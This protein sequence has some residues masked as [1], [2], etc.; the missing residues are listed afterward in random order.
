M[1]GEIELQLVQQLEVNG[2]QVLAEHCV[3]ALEGDFL[4]GLG[5]R[6]SCIFLSGVL[7]GTDAGK[8]LKDLREKFRAVEPVSFVA[9]INTAT[10]MDKVIIEKM[11]VKELAGKPERFEYAFTLREYTPL[12]PA[13][14]EEP[15]KPDV[16]KPPDNNIDKNT[17]TLRV[18]VIVEGQTDFDYSHVVVT[19]EGKETDGTDLSRTLTNR[20]DNIWT[21]E[22]FPAG[23]FTIK[24]SANSQP[25]SGS[26]K[27]SVQAGQTAQVTI[28]LKAVT[29]NIARAF[30]V[31]F[32]FDKA[33]I[34]PCMRQVL[35]AAAKYASDHPDE[36]L[37]IAGHTDLVGDSDYNQSL[38]E[39][40]ARAVYAY[41]T[42]GLDKEAAVK[43]WNELRKKATGEKHDIKD[44]WS[45]REYQFMLQDLD[46]YTGNID[47]QH[48]PK[49][50]AAIRSFQQFHS[51]PE[52]GIVDDATW[53]ALIGDYLDQDAL[54]MPESQFLKNSK[55]GCDGGILKWLG[56]GEQDP[57]KNTQDAWRPN[58]RTEL[59]F[60]QADKIPCEIPKPVTFDRPSTGAVGS[61]WCL[62]P[63]DGD[64]RCCFTSRD[65]EQ[66]NKWLIQPAEPGNITVSGSIT[67]DDGT[68][69]ANAKYA[70]I[71]PDGEFLHT[72][73]SGKPDLGE[74]PQGSQRGR[75]IPN[76]ADEN[77][78]F[79]YPRETPVGIYTMMLLD[80]KD[81]QVART[82][83]EPKEDAVGN[84]ICTRLSLPTAR[85]LGEAQAGPAQLDTNVQQGPVPPG[86]VNP[87][88][89]LASSIVV[90][91][92][93]YTSPA[94][95]QVTLSTSSAFKRSGTLTS[96]G[97]AIKLFTA[98]SGGSQI[99][100]NG[101][102]NVFPGRSLSRGVKLFAEST[103]PSATLDDYKLTLTLAPGPTP[104]GP[105][106]TVTMTA[107][108]LTLDICMSRTA[109]GVDPT[110]LPQPPVTPPPSGTT[111]KDKWFGGRFVQVPGSGD[112]GPG[113]VINDR[114]RALL[115]VRQ[116]QPSAFVGKLVLRQVS[117]RGNKIGSLDN[118]LQA[119]SFEI[120]IGGD[121][122]RANPLELDSITIPVT[123]TKF[124]VEG[125]NISATFRDIGFQLGIKDLE[126]DGD[127]VAATSVQIEAIEKPTPTASSIKFVR[128]GI[129]DKAYDAAGNIRNNL[130]ENDNF[131]GAD[132]RKFHIRVRGP[133]LNLPVQV[134]WKTLKS[135]SKDD[136]APASQA[137][138]LVAS[139]TNIFISKAIMLVTDATDRDF[140]T[141]SGFAPPATD[142]GLRNAGQ[143][144]H[145]TR[146]ADID[147]FVKVEYL[148]ASGVVLPIIEP[149]FSRD[150]NDE[151]RRVNARVIR[152]TNPGVS[153]FPVATDAY[154]ASQFQH[155]NQRWS[156]VGIQVDPQPTVDRPIPAGA[157]DATG[158]YGGSANNTQEQAALSDLI[159]ITPD[160]TL[161][162]V[163]VALNGANA[164]STT[165]PRNPIPQPVG[166]P[167]TLDERHFVFINPGLPIEGDTLAHEMHHVL[168]NRGDVEVDRQ[169][170]T[171]NTN[172]SIFYGIPL[173]DVRVRRRVHN[174][175]TADPN[176]DPANDNVINWARRRR[177]SRFPIS[178]D[179][180]PGATASTGN[181][182]ASRF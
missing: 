61:T 75:P 105:D 107:V 119:F 141:H 106:A 151:R 31:H 140:P 162:I 134:N 84:V 74:W 28:S 135:D 178:G 150:A 16:P 179:L 113:S 86:A 92:K 1:L 43:E 170:F 5:R 58:R 49:T 100:F 156:Q 21:E 80:L 35:Q 139:G 97:S 19:V 116:V 50:S 15:P 147:G 108:G 52:N 12:P 176:N 54:A 168:F 20:T 81:P 154:I 121:I 128:F 55:N 159:P 91:K 143:S 40:R 11:E 37:V 22:K 64:N 18:E 69:V 10:K 153:G 6:G 90:A 79:S 76:Q 172:P 66:P 132:S 77:G 41:V 32:W 171:F 33:F 67:F 146:K 68:P 160:D 101:K 174:F 36:K 163:F 103:T 2:I 144:N 110:P 47:E 137:L 155:V 85:A 87:V 72:D 38:S 89:T 30:T 71:A 27:T 26:A 63:D 44:S 24:A 65:S 126:N 95:V 34:E 99:T 8:G 51:L 122:A 62:G 4:Q 129:W 167:L 94:R 60:V 53:Q 111:A 48:S 124:W 45:T 164:Y 133:A 56:C 9:D 115:I 114:D 169:F 78:K 39:R 182:L 73:S 166:G 46:Y 17:G 130:A 173:P 93:S 177:T 42:A 59:L 112:L 142:A 120:P 88:I 152:Y 180:N 131:V 14:T 136:D 23:D 96:S 29:S 82:A 148:P 161:T 125:K 127:R 25:M 13:A 70:L 165:F 158:L 175:H 118:K 102:D 109:I 57:V 123:G 7:T 157:L 117:I 3:P 83:D 181:R 145:R 138:T 149:V 104:V 98:A